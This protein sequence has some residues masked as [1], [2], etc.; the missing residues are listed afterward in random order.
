MMCELPLLEDAA[1]LT[2]AE[3]NRVIPRFCFQAHVVG[4]KLRDEMLCLCKHKR[5][6]T[7]NAHSLKHD[8]DSTKP[9][10][11]IENLLEL[12]WRFC[13]T[14]GVHV[15]RCHMAAMRS[16]CPCFGQQHR[17]PGVE[18]SSSRCN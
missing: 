18:C 11:C 1:G 4:N 14:N 7:I 10:V 5:G 9:A 16:R 6:S 8:F 17:G 12:S 13:R 2:R 15:W 3:T